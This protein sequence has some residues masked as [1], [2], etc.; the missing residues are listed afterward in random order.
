MR[1]GSRYD[2]E[3]AGL[4]SEKSKTRHGSVRIVSR[5]H[6][7]LFISLLMAA[8]TASAETRL[9]VMSFN[10]RYG[11]DGKGRNSWGKRRETVANAI[12]QQ[13]PAVVGLQECIDFQA[14]YL[15]EAL[16]EYQWIGMG[17][18][19]DGGHEMTAVLYRKKVLSPVETSNF[20][21]SET[22]DVPGSRSWDSAYE[23]MA[24]QVRFMHRKTGAI[25]HFVN[26]HL[27][28]RG[29]QA[30]V[31]GAK[32]IVQRVESIP[33]IVPVIVTGDYNALAEKSEPWRVFEEAGFL[34][35]WVIA[36]KRVGPE[37][38][39]S[40]FRAPK[41]DSIARIDW[42]LVRGPVTVQRCETSVYNDDGRYPSDHF[43]IVAELTLTD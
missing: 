1:H 8:L 20:W 35:S 33:A 16:P 21:L 13:H 22:P 32:L 3:T 2:L 37:I 23:R 15:V 10:I 6:L 29:K 42:V 41:K 40:R 19:A 25:F 39:I 12:K 17:R 14:E 30:R 28:S 38:T 18:E 9:T 31:E 7:L 27:D 4:T 26:T 36:R 24:T 11:T 43:P 34:D 5:R